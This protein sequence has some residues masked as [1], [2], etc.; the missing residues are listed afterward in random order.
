M[1]KIVLGGFV[2][3]LLGTAQAQQQRYPFQDSSA[4]VE[5]RVTDLISRMTLAEKIDALGTNPTVPRLGVVGTG[6][7]EGL[8]GLALG[9]PG[10]WE[11]KNLTVIP[12]T[13]FPQSRGPRTDVGPVAD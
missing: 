3:A 8:H 5:A 6:H 12:T 1:I 13:Q 7:V 4:D 2:L 11:G 9:G 10:G